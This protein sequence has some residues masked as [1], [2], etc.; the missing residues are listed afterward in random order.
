MGPH[1]LRAGLA[2]LIAAGLL[3]GL[4]RLGRWSRERLEKQNYYTVTFADI[5]CDVPPGR[6]P[7]DFLS[8][9]QY[10]GSLPDQFSVLEPQIIIR[11][12][13]AFALHP[14]VER[15]EG[16][17]LRAPDGPHVRLRLRT[18]ALAAAG[19]VLDANGVLLPAGASADGLP[20]LRGIVP[21]PTGP[22]G[23]PWG[24]ATVEAAARTAAWLQG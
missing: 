24:D 1:G 4:L 5:R 17:A 22:A 8:E 19:R 11:L 10:L 23:T 3:F 14:W 7:A 13:A 20:E 16:V 18:P 6:T 12:T 2:L 21:P 9:V 15:V